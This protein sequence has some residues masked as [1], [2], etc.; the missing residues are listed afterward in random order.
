MSTES[1]T[2]PKRRSHLDIRF[3]QRHQIL[4]D[5]AHDEVLHLKPLVL[6][7]LDPVCEFPGL[8]VAGGPQVDV[9]LPFG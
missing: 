9:H 1:P 4:F 2:L 8:R 5:F 3:A 6:F 7:I